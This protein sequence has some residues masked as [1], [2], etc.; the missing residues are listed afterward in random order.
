MRQSRP[1]VDERS[2]AEPMQEDTGR[3]VS[4]TERGGGGRG[5]ERSF[6]FCISYHAVNLSDL[7]GGEARL[8]VG[9]L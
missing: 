8:F 2:S 7:G 6:V 4:S 5:G 1:T 9:E 3:A